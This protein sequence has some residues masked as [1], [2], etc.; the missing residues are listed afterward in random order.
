[1]LGTPS[2]VLLEITHGTASGHA[3]LYS[4]TWGFENTA[5]G[6]SALLYNT[7]GADN[8]ASGVGALFSNTTGFENT[9]SVLYALFDNTTGASNTAIGSN[10]GSNATTGSYNVSV[11][12]DVTGTAADTNTIRIGLPYNGTTNPP[13]GQNQTFIAG[14]YG[15]SV[16]NWL[17]V[18]IDATGK[19]GTI[20][21]QTGGGM[22]APLSK[23][24]V[25]VVQLQHQVR[26]QQTTITDLRATIADQGARLARL[27]SLL[28]GAA[29][30]GGK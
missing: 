9:A 2:A 27:E 5:I 22:P 4:N 11:G 12:A 7:T 26:D 14:I 8:T 3:A 28:S 1:M 20:N 18:V 6:R 10:A 15:T 19:L 21:P 30:P 17:P 13:S 24:D 25:T 16:T 23:T 29:A